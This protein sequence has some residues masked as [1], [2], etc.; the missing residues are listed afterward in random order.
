[1]RE[2]YRIALLPGDGI[3]PEVV[4][5]AVRVLRALEAD[6][7]GLCFETEEFSV[8][9]DEYLRNGDALP[10]RVF[11]RLPEFHA[12][13]LGAMGLPG[14]RYADG[15]EIAPQLD[16]RERLDLYEGLRPIYLF[17]PDDSPL[18]GQKA[19]GIDLLLVRESTEGLFSTRKAIR[20]PAADRATDTMSITRAGAERVV[21][22]AF[23]L[24]R[25]RRNKV[26]LV[27]KA[28]VL[29]SMAFFRRI[30]DEVAREFPAVETERV[31][32][33]A[34]ALY[35]VQRPGSFDVMVTENM[36]GDILSDLTAALVGGMG[37][38][39]SADIGDRYAVFQ[40]SHGSAPDIA[41]EGIANPV[42][43]ILSAAMMLDW[44]GRP[45][46]RAG[47]ES[48]RA[49]VKQV[50]RDPGRRTRDMGGTLSTGQMTDAIVAALRKP[51]SGNP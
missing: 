4:G 40:P 50:F 31:Y 37:M 51:G 35:L 9:A 36:F 17:H 38:A 8:G 6:I 26:A 25:A 16:L 1:V 27:D 33:D 41:G 47:A 45:G 10:E 24:A 46:A 22:A 7:A 2:T 30:F 20:D 15:V 43:T 3:G 19:G 49:A 23:R 28:N 29:P 48:I 18:R 12:I 13:L 34:A 21:R 11:E 14:V 32:V 44:L 42:A 5:E 39:P